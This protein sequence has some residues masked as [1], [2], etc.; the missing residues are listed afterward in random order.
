VRIIN[1]QDIKSLKLIHVYITD[2]KTEQFSPLAYLQKYFVCN[3]SSRTRAQV[4]DLDLGGFEL[5]IQFYLIGFFYRSAG[6]VSQQ[7]P[8]AAGYT[9]PVL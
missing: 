7:A 2:L 6:C 5:H 3:N 8:A 4:D 9:L 1:I